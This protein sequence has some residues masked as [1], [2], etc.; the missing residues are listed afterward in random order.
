[1][2]V[3]AALAPGGPRHPAGHARHGGEGSDGMPCAWHAAC[4]AAWQPP[5]APDSRCRRKQASHASAATAPGATPPLP[6]QR[7]SDRMMG[8]PCE[9]QR[10]SSPGARAAGPRLAR[11]ARPNGACLKSSESPTSATGSDGGAPDGGASLTRLD[12]R[13]KDGGVGLGG[14]GAGAAAVPA[15]R[16]LY[17]CLS[18]LGS[19]IAIL[20]RL[21]MGRWV[22][23][24]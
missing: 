17:P 22:L 18:P 12:K 20:P 4:L 16:V 6:A 7:R 1:V 14:G 8:E 5:L 24:C 15:G 23:A 11:G 10:V 19:L 21:G 3:R 9:R 2:R 13:D